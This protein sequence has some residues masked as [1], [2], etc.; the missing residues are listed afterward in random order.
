[1]YDLYKVYVR[2]KSKAR[3]GFITGDI[4]EDHKECRDAHDKCRIIVHLDWSR[5]ISA[6]VVEVSDIESAKPTK[7]N[8]LCVQ[9][10]PLPTGVPLL[11]LAKG[12]PRSSERPITV[13]SVLDENKMWDV[14]A[15]C[16]TR[17]EK[18]GSCGTA[19]LSHKRDA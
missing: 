11:L 17:V 3:A 8:Q 5:T 14:E 2:V 12:V 19:G 15:V 7:K 16:L 18:M 9:V 10:N 6:T 13:C 1:M 4:G